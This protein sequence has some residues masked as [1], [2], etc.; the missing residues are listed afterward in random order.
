[1]SNFFEELKKSKA[2]KLTASYLG[3]CFVILQVLDPLSE[4]GIV[5]EEFF[6]LILYGLIGGIPVPLIIGFLTDRVKRKALGISF[7]MNTNVIFSFMGLFVIF[8]LSITNIEL[9]QSSEKINWAR[10]E[11]IPKLY[12]LIQDGKNET[13]YRLALEIENLIP[14]DSMLVRALPKISRN[15]SIYTNLPGVSIYRKAYGDTVNTYEHLGE[16]NLE[17]IRFP[18]VYSTLKMEKEGYE[19]IKIEVHPYYLNTGENLFHLPKIGSIPNGMVLIPGGSTM[20][21][22]SGLDHL[23]KIK[24]NSY[25]LDINEVTNREYQKFVNDGGYEQKQYWPE[26]IVYKNKKLNFETMITMFND[27]TGIVGPATWEAGQ[28]PDGKGDHPVSGVSWFEAKAYAN[29]MG[30]SLPSLYHWNRAANTRASASI[31]PTSNF[32]PNGTQPVGASGGRSPFGN[33]DMAGNV[34]EWCENLSVNNSRVILGG[35][36][37]DERYAFNDFYSQDP[38]DRSFINGIR[39]IKKIEEDDSNDPYVEIELP[40]RDYYTEKPVSDEVYQYFLKQF[41]Y[42]NTDLEPIIEEIDDSYIHAISEKITFN[43]AYDNE[44][45]IAYLYLPKKT[46]PPYKTILYF[47]GSNAIHDRNSNVIKPNSFEYILKAGYAVIFPIY[48]GTYERGTGLDSDYQNETNFYK[49]HVVWW[50]K[51]L[52]RSIDYLE[53]RNDIDAS[54]IAYYGVSW[55]GLM[56]NIMIPIEKRFKAGLLRVAG[57]GFQKALPEADAFNYTS[58]I[59]IPTIMMNGKY[60]QFFPLETSQKPMFKLIG[61]PNSDKKHYVFETGH[62]VPKKELAKEMLGWLKV[63]LK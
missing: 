35:G 51:D 30:K 57:L 16:S 63:Y 34:R 32:N 5:N 62:S 54:N 58:R 11:A 38:W 2:F 23:D 43:A 4:R 42:D 20:L 28:Y 39:C 56:G 1:M 18:W 50:G 40:Y 21:N 24:L 12:Q 52:K 55:G 37:S 14:N 45:L 31:V 3:V 46:K 49:D 8:Y 19:T 7:K 47:P 25:Y 13:A 59:N 53:T 27:Q 26:N 61:T 9:K 48:K 29:Y 33:N 41:N 36:Y 6:Q 15:V 60:D 44:R 10:Q 22:I 17:N